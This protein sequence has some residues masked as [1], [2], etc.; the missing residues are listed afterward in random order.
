MPPRV[1]VPPEDVTITVGLDRLLY[2]VDT[3]LRHVAAYAVDGSVAACWALRPPEG[4]GEVEAVAVNG[5]GTLF[6]LAEIG[7]LPNVLRAARGARL[8]P[9]IGLEAP[10]HQKLGSFAHFLAVANDG[11]IY[12][13]AGLDSLRVFDPAGQLLWSSAAIRRAAAGSG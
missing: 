11:R 1:L 13:A 9:F 4:T 7:G 10:Q 5:D 12:V 8:E 6:A 2:L 3:R